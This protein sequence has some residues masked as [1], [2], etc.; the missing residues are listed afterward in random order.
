MIEAS[1]RLT[2]RYFPFLDIRNE[3]NP[4]IRIEPFR[5]ARLIKKH[6]VYSDTAQKQNKSKMPATKTNITNDITN[7]LIFK[8][9]PSCARIHRRTSSPVAFLPHN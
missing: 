4:K 6:F 9:L 1:N 8:R 2:Y 5:K 3:E 7:F